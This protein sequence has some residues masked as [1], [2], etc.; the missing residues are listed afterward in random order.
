[1]AAS[2]T[3]PELSSW[4]PNLSAVPSL[5][6]VSSIQRV[7]QARR[8]EL[9]STLLFYHPPTQPVCHKVLSTF[10]A[11]SPSK[12]SGSQSP[13]CYH[14]SSR[15][16]C[17]SS[18]QRPL[19]TLLPVPLP[20]RKPEKEE[21]VACCLKSSKLLGNTFIL[22]IKILNPQHAYKVLHG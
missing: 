7:T 13:V 2:Q 22:G 16:N 6:F 9:F 3:S 12:L 19:H 20:T 14:P 15:H 4:L 8:L 21:K 1:M 11:K 10:L 18:L 17:L 5:F